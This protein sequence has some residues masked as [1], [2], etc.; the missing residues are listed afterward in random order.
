MLQGA[1]SRSPDFRSGP[2]MASIFTH[3]IRREAPAEIVY[4]TDH[5]I[6][7]LD[8]Y[9]ASDGH[10][11]V[12]PKREVAGF[13][14]LTPEE[15][16]ALMQGVQRV[17]QGAMRALNTSHY[18]IMVNNGSAAGQV[19]YHVHVHVIPRWPGVPREKRPLDPRKARDIGAKLRAAIGALPG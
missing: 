6:A 4:E 17:A 18:N 7:F 9:P 5:L 12:V 16:S 11:L 13:E 2:P 1:G 15:L 19:V 10:T 8:V 3:I 14:E